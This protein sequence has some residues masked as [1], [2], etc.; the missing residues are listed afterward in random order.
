M[1]MQ[2][3]AIARLVGLVAM[4]FAIGGPAI[5]APKALVHAIPAD[6]ASLDPADIRGQQDQ[7]IGVNIYER[8]GQMKF[9][10]Q[11]DGTLMA[12][13]VEVVPQLAESWK[14]EGPVITFKLRPGVKFFATGNPVTAEDVRYSFERLVRITGNGKNQAGIAGLFKAEQI[15]AV[16]PMTVKI[17]FTDGSGT[18]TAIPVALTSMKFQQFAV[19]D[20]VEVKKHVTAEDPWANQWLIKNLATTGPYYIANRTLGQQLELKAVT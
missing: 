16:D 3:R 14:V 8:L 20:S 9:N 10:E 13:P 5:A 19:I 12:D 15:E 7:E 6:I 4:A 11:K 18:P 2:R 17:T 1:P